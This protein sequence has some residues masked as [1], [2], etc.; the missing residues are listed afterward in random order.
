MFKVIS[1]VVAVAV[2]SAELPSWSYNSFGSGPYPP[3]GWRPAGPEFRLPE[4]HASYGPPP[5]EYL[6]PP[7]QE[8]GPPPQE[9]GPP[10]QEYGPPSQEYGPPSSGE[11]TTTEADVTTT[12]QATTTEASTEATTETA[13]EVTTEAES[14]NSLDGEEQYQ[15]LTQPAE[16][17]GV[18]FIYHP[19]GLLQ[20]IIYTT[21]D[22]RRNMAYTASF[23]YENVEPIT[24]PVYTYDPN[25]F[26][27]QR[28]N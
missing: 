27:F 24:G 28:V 20:R 14:A 3:S 8:Y 21:N 2:V 13:T 7:T 4:P 15:K 9:Y 5:Q 23:K 6:A 12:E 25:T 16:E 18:Y 17:K 1:F 11:P 26:A 19:S 22:D 10:P